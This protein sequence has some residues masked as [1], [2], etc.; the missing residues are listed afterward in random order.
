MINES[1]VREYVSF[2]QSY[3]NKRLHK[4]FDEEQF[5][6]IC[7][8]IN[9]ILLLWTGDTYVGNKKDAVVEQAY[10]DFFVLLHD[11]LEFCLENAKLLSEKEASL[12]DFMMFRGTVYRYLGKCDSRNYR[13]KVVVE[14]EYND[15]YVSWSKSESNAYIESKLY[16]PRTW[17]RAEISAPDF[18]IDIHGFELW[19]EKWFGDSSFITRGEE[20]EVVFPTIESSVREMRYI[21]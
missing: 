16:G 12:A 18:G 2:V 13:K 3:M 17:M 14:P 8:G 19:C 21:K 15:I 9:N 6:E 20:K 4:D 5:T 10:Q 1:K 11:F 7:A